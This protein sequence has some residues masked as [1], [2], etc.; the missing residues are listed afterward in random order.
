MWSVAPVSATR[1]L[2]AGR[3]FRNANA[4]DCTGGLARRARENEFC[5][6]DHLDA[7]EIDRSGVAAAGGWAEGAEIWVTSGGRARDWVVGGGMR[8]AWIEG[9]VGFRISA[10]CLEQLAFVFPFVVVLVSQ[11][12]GLQIGGGCESPRCGSRPPTTGFRRSH[13]DQGS[14]VGACRR[15]HFANLRGRVAVSRGTLYEL[16]SLSAMDGHDPPLKN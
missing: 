12:V 15:H 8:G 9:N 4:V 14:C 5:K 10:I 3:D 6:L 7:L 16:N 11:I 2:E 13:R 1:R